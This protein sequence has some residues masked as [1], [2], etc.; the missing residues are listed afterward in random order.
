MRLTIFLFPVLPVI[1]NH[2]KLMKFE[3]DQAIKGNAFILK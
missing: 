2:M 3:Y 1:Y